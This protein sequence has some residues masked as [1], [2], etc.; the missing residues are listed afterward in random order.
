MHE[1]VLKAKYQICMSTYEVALKTCFT[2]IS[3]IKQLHFV[4]TFVPLSNRIE[5]NVN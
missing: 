5:L 3:F 4:F 2:L 1:N